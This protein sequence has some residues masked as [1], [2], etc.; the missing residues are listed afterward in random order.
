METL[1]HYIDELHLARPERSSMKLRSKGLFFIILIPTNLKCYFHR[2][3]RIN[4]HILSLRNLLEMSN[5]VTKKDKFSVLK[6]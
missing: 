4:S 5:I 3:K 6:K 2:T 1:T